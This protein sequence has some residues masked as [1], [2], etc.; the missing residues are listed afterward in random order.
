LEDL[1]PKVDCKIAKHYT[2]QREKNISVL[3]CYDLAGKLFTAT[4]AARMN[5]QT[6]TADIFLSRMEHFKLNNTSIGIIGRVPK[7]C[8]IAGV[9]ILID[10]RDVRR[11]ILV[12]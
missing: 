6:V 4:L 10:Q 3:V 1:G 5:D 12:A 11:S 2:S 7:N 8:I 9:P